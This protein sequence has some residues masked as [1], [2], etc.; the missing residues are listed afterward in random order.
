MP[1]KH[2]TIPRGM[3]RETERALT[4]VLRGGQKSVPD[5][6][7]RLRCHHVNTGFGLSKGAVSYRQM[8]GGQLQMLRRHLDLPREHLR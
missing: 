3:L 5:G 4:N 7:E 2:L 1:P 8:P 6:P